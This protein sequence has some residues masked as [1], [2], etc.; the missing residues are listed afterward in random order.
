MTLAHW[1]RLIFVATALCGCSDGDDAGAGNGVENVPYPPPAPDDCI[2]DVTPGHQ[3]LSCDELTFE[4]T[5]P[6]S[7]LERACGLIFDT[8][9]YGMAG[10]LENLHTRLRDLGGAA[11]YIVVNPNAPGQ[12]P[13]TAWDAEHDD[14][15]FAFMQRVMNV[16]H[17]DRKRIHFTGYSQG[18]WMT[19]RFACA[20]ADIL[21][22]V[23]PL[24]AGT[25]TEGGSSCAF[26]GDAVPSRALPILFAHGTADGLVPF[27]TAEAQRDAVIAAWGLQ[28]TEILMTGPD[29]EWQR[30]TNSSGAVLE[31]AKHDWSTEFVLPTLPALKGHCFPGSGEFLGCGAETSFN[32][33]EA[34][35]RFFQDHPMPRSSLP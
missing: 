35:L 34:V 14:H 25:S 23:A 28:P 21:A 1:A 26:T 12:V 8:H 17:V 4:L 16:W 6:E 7:C 11:G 13:A 15:V 29:Y 31:F 20:H 19:W 27:S 22:S 9:G 33:G 10:E 2:Q 18:G 5:V 32:W 24:A 3:T 30:Y